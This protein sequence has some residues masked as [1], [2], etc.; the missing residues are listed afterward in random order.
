MFRTEHDGLLI[1]YHGFRQVR[2][3]RRCTC[4]RRC[5]GSLQSHR[6]RSFPS[7][8]N[9]DEKFSVLNMVQK[10]RALVAPSMGSPLEFQDVILESPRPD[11]ALVE[12]HATGVCHGDIGCITG[13]TP[14]PF[15][16]VLGHEGM[17]HPGVPLEHG[18][19]DT[20]PLAQAV[21]L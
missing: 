21:A 19:S 1:D 8:K 6:G 11:E 9:I 20:I 15:P 4:G 17:L 2:A 3:C 7:N 16:I 18:Q 12:I 14:V 5:A 13:K 10:A